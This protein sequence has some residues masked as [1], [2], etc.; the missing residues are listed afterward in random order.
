MCLW[1]TDASGGNKVKLWQKS[2]VP[3]F[4]PPHPQGYGMSVKC[5]EPL[6][7]A[8][9]QVWLLYEHPNFKYCTLI[10][11]GTELRT[12]GRTD[13]QTDDPI[14]RRPRQTF[15]AGVIKINWQYLNLF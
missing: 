3:H 5:E 7:E 2:L 14:T 11:S 10:V 13:R 6:D 1:N 15:Q 4:D 9:V 8:T 12:D